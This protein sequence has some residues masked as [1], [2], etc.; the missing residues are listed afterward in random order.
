MRVRAS[1][2]KRKS[3]RCERTNQEEATLLICYG[4]RLHM[5]RRD[6][7]ESGRLFTAF[8][9]IRKRTSPDANGQG[10]LEGEISLERL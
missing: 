7:A 6:G 2:R 10:W 9:E 1:R 3:A 4:R 8:I 5:L